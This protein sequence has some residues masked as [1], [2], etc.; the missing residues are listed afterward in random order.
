MIAATRA[1]QLTA[2]N[3][4]QVVKISLAGVWALPAWFSL[5]NFACYSAGILVL[6]VGLAVAMKHFPPQTTALEKLLYCAPVLVAA[7]LAIFGAEHLLDPAGVGRLIPAWI[8]AHTFWALLVGVCLVLAALSIMAQKQV[9]LALGLFGILMLCFEALIH[10]PGAVSESKNTFAWSIVCREFTFGMGALA[11]AATHT[12]EG[13][14][15]GKHWLIKVARL[16]MGIALI[17]FGVR[18]LFKPELLP[19]VPLVQPTPNFSPLRLL[20]GY[21]NGAVYVIGGAGLVLNKKAAEAA[22]WVGVFVLGTAI[23]FCIPY[24]VQKNFDVGTGLNVPADTM[25]F[26]GSILCLAG[27]LRASG[28]VKC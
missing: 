27:S 3:S 6:V 22:I 15:S 26:S 9:A 4:S 1:L 24:M 12:L 14:T 19:G 11:F 20:W 2:I 28:K 8:P 25:L 5:E 18:Y 10:V 23:V 21:L 16:I 7:P 13:K 17:F